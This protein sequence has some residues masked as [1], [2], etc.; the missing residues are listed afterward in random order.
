[1]PEFNMKIISLYWQIGKNI[2]LSYFLIFSVRLVRL[3][4]SLPDDAV[5]SSS[6]SLFKSF[7]RFDFSG[8]I[9]KGA[10]N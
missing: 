6:F 5:S 10:C 7:L 2:Y 4:N 3:W 9:S 1:M 8:H